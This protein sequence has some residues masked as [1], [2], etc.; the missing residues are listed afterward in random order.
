M[1]KLNLL[2]LVLALSVNLS[3]FAQE[4]QTQ[5]LDSLNFEAQTWFGNNQMLYDL[6]DSVSQLAIATENTSGYEGGFDGSVVYWVPLK[7]W[8]YHTN[9][10][11]G[12]S[13][14]DLESPVRST[15]PSHQ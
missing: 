13:R 10:N 1:K 5:P 15:T 14:A 2:W 8:V 6:V 9:S 7:F 12:A 4:C 11:T 3:A